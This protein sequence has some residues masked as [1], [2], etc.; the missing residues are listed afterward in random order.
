VILDTD[1]LEGDA[2]YRDDL[3]HRFLTDMFFAAELLGFND[4]VPRVHQEAF[5]LYGPKVPELGIF[6]QPRKHK[7][8]HLDPRHTF[9]TTAKRIDRVQLL[10][11]FSE[12]ITFLVESATQPLAEAIGKATSKYFFRPKGAATKPLQMLFPEIVTDKNPSFNSVDSQ[13][14]AWNTPNRRETGAGDLDATIAITSPQSTQSGWHPTHIDPDDVEDTKN[15][16][17][18]ANPDVRQNVIDICDQNENLLRTG[19][20]ITIGGTRYH[21]FDWYGRLI[22]RAQMDP[23]AWGVLVRCSV[24]TKNGSLLLPGEFPREDEVEL[25]FPELPNL[26]YKELRAKFYANYEAFMCQ[27]QNDPQGGNVPTFPEQL[28]AGCAIAEERLPRSHHAQSFICWRPRYGGNPAMTRFSE[29]AAATVVDGRVFINDCWQ[30]TYTPSGEAERIVQYAKD[31]DV[32]LVMIIGV[33]GSEYL[34]AH[35][36]NEAQRKNRSVRIQWIEFEEDDNRRMGKIKQLEPLMKVG[37]VLFSTGMS[38]AAEC[39]KQ[40][41][42]YG[43]VVENGIIEC[44]ARFADLVPIAQMRA[45]MEEEE[46][47]YQRRRRDD[48]MVQ[49]FLEQQGMPAVD[50]RAQQQVRAHQAAMSQAVSW[51]IPPLPGGLDG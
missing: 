35:I 36:R 23:E 22:E 16:G 11:A 7:I 49:S 50:E 2:A 9:K 37:R 3:R 4:F 24:K 45:N 43:L 51:G 33:P 17:I 13:R 5:D 44:V 15:S 34:A 46:I 25:Q 29:G 10:C 14:W 48:A 20:Y 21:P 38:K 32:D 6:E 31:H 28:Y 41:V 19:G 42:H 47:Q 1:K 30:G 27:Q 40:F 18:Q 12:E 26:S 8:I 39:H